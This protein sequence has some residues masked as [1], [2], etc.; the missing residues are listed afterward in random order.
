MTG[1]EEWGKSTYATKKLLQSNSDIAPYGLGSVLSGGGGGPNAAGGTASQWKSMVDNFQTFALQSRLGIP[2]P[3]G[4]DAVPANN[5][6]SVAVIF[7][8]T[9]RM[10]APRAA[11]L[12]QQYP[13]LTPRL[14]PPPSPRTSFPSLSSC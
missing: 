11:A 10:A 2:L 12:V 1:A 3:Y 13:N 4:L 6:V 5:T 9:I 8:L 7:P 14:A